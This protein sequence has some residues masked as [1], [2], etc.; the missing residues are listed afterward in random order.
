M[1][2]NEAPMVGG[3]RADEWLT[4]DGPVV[5]AVIAAFAAT[6][7]EHHGHAGHSIAP[8]INWI[9]VQNMRAC[10]AALRAGQVM[11]TAA[12]DVIVASAARRTA[13]GSSLD[14]LIDAYHLGLAEAWKQLA[15]HA[16]GDDLDAL[17]EIAG[18]M[19]AYLGHVSVLVAR[20]FHEETA[21][22]SEHERDS[23]FAV[24]SALLSGD[25]H[26]AAARR[27][28]IEL[29][30]HY[31]VLSYETAP[32][33]DTSDE[34]SAVT[35]R[36][37]TFRVRREL[38]GFG[39]GPALGVGGSR[40][41]AALVPVREGVTTADV[42]QLVLRLADAAESP[43]WCGWA[44]A[45][46]QDAGA[47]MSIAEEVCELVR[48]LGRTPGAYGLDDVL[49]EFHVTRA[50]AASDRIVALAESLPSQLLE[51]LARYVDSGYDRR[52]TAA[53]LH[54]HPNTVDYRLGRIQALTGRSVA[55]ARDRELLVAG[56]TMIAAR[57]G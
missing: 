25:G 16:S 22:T 48:R 13:E 5:A 28:G 56:L 52:A 7:P 32:A 17:A 34:P 47:Q 57:A 36:R 4:D 38:D 12:D 15:S 11:P 53:A 18:V 8:D 37:R 46:P 2:H 33:A 39:A 43:V 19:F 41:G 26:D 1:H 35:E 24:Y 49:F 40:G 27:A 6:N 30:E 50:S 9:V 44:T 20:G 29:P 45:A 10:A 31:L 42:E 3:R 21:R 23:R 14:A 51:T 55:D 54:V